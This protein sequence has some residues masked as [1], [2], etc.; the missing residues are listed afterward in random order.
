MTHPLLSS[1]ASFSL[2]HQSHVWHHRILVFLISAGVTGCCLRRLI[3]CI[4]YAGS[5]LWPAYLLKEEIGR[6]SVTKFHLQLM[7]CSL[8]RSAQTL[9]NIRSLNCL[10]FCSLCGKMKPCLLSVSVPLK[11]YVHIIRN[12][13]CTCF[14]FTCKL[15]ECRYLEHGSAPNLMQCRCRM[16]LHRMSKFKR[17][18]KKSVIVAPLPCAHQPMD[19]SW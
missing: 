7:L 19:Y 1:S 9:L 3:S 5:N 17:S 4:P 13:M 6:A 8:S 2:L 14:A 15:I 16:K 12:I 18:E 11:K 10:V